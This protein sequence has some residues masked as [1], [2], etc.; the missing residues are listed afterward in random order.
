MP[1]AFSLPVL[2]SLPDLSIA[3]DLP[4]SDA[5]DAASSRDSVR[6]TGARAARIP[7]QRSQATM[8]DIS[9]QSN[10]SAT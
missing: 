3:L 10:P 5:G 4:D 2:R 9:S 1:L 8:A 6:E 7:M